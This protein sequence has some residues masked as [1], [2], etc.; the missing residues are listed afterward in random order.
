MQWVAPVPE[1]AYVFGEAYERVKSFNNE[2]YFTSEVDVGSIDALIKELNTVIQRLNQNQSGVFICSSTQRKRIILY[3]D[4]PGGTLKDCFKFIDFIEAMKGVHNIM[5]VTVCTGL[6]A[7]A[8]TLMALTGEERYVTRNVTCMIHELF[9]GTMGTYTQLSAGMKHISIYHKKLISLYL[10]YNSKL[11]ETAIV[12][13]LKKETWFDAQEYIDSG[14][15]QA[16]Y[17]QRD[18][19]EKPHDGSSKRKNKSKRKRIREH[20]TEDADAGADA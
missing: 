7:S 1:T 17:M 12:D 16:I 5:F 3:I 4:S 14:F 13:L 20:A 11:D 2:I 8:A 18:E 10:E 19:E 15:A 6:V 9:G